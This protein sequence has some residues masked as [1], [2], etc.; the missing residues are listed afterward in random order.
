MWH[1]GLWYKLLQIGV[2]KKLWK[3][4]IEMYD[5]FQC[6]VSVGGL[7]T[8]W[9]SVTQGVHQG[10]PYSLWLYNIFIN[11][12]IGALRESRLGAS[13]YN[14]NI[15]CIGYAD[16]LALIATSHTNLQ[17]LVHMAYE[18]SKKWC[19]MYNHNKSEVICFGA[20]QNEMANVCFWLG[21][22]KLPIVKAAKHL[23]VILTD[24][25][26]LKQDSLKDKI[27]SGRRALFAVQGIG[28]RQ[29]PLST[30]TLASIYWKVSVPIIT[31]G[32]DISC[33]SQEM[34]N[35]LDD[36]HWAVAKQIQRLPKNTPN[37]VVLPQLGWWSLSC[38][39]DYLC[40]NFIWRLLML[41][42]RN[43]YK[44]V[45]IMSL[46]SNWFCLHDNINMCSPVRSILNVAQRYNVVESLITSVTSANYVSKEEWKNN[47]KGVISVVNWQ[48]HI[49]TMSLYKK[50]TL[51]KKCILIPKLS[52][53]WNHESAN[54][55]YKRKCVLVIRLL[56]N[57]EVI[58]ENENCSTCHEMV[59]CTL[60]HVLFECQAF[61]SLRATEWSL[62]EQNVPHPFMNEM[63]RMDACTRTIFLLNGFNSSYVKEFNAIYN[64]VAD[65]IWTL[66]RA[67]QNSIA[68]II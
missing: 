63:L 13:A 56:T 51:Y 41:P 19:Y 54:P 61:Q 55:L 67:K 64:S 27:K 3:N 9:F 32:L 16:D 31:Y 50:V 36:M 15:T 42:T 68:L 26:S 44:R 14:V 4:I 20:K 47:L 39:V 28:T 6:A 21:E 7:K 34:K 25:N 49:C 59:P 65:F 60:Q 12:L 8:E 30:K 52:P 43:I 5:S 17:R 11:D 29:T 45:A 33:P 57:V 2:D 35:R 18:H 58:D 37:P 48:N 66:V 40:L 62:L 24:C 23:G 38:Y 22:N 46:L 53:W 1:D 10:A